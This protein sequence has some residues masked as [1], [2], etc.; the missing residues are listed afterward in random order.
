MK[1]IQKFKCRCSGIGQIMTESRGKTKTEKLADLRTSLSDAQA[2]AMNTKE[3]TKSRAA[4]AERVDKILSNIQ[5]VLQLPDVPELSQ[6]AKTFCENWLTQ[7]LYERRREFVTRYTEKGKEME[8]EAADY[9]A[10]VLGWGYVE[11]NTL[12]LDNE[13]I[14]GECDIITNDAIHDIKNSYDCFTFPLFADEIPED[15]YYWQVQGYMWLYD[16]PAASVV[17]CLMDM[18]D[19][20]VAWECRIK[21]GAGYSAE[22]FAEMKALHTYSHLPDYLRVKQFKFER[23][24]SDIDRIAARVEQCREYINTLIK[25]IQKV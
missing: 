11:P 1:D 22:Q 9:A 19:N 2:K 15:G 18:P 25:K 13:W 17:Y 12:R 6:T 24:Q 5:E 20:L 21:Y 4:A 8:V 16:R 3:G 10:G 14:Q 7:Q 23:N